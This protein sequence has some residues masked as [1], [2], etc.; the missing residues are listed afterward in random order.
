[1]T[2]NKLGVV[3][4]LRLCELIGEVE[5]LRFTEAVGTG[6]I[7]AEAVEKLIYINETKEQFTKR[8]EID[9]KKQIE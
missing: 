2:R 5:A 8:L 7:S 9:L 6:V 1:M 4:F 3:G